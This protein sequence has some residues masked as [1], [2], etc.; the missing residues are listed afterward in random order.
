MVF[1]HV[2]AQNRHREIP[3]ALQF[4]TYVAV[5]AVPANQNDS[6]VTL[7]DPAPALRFP[8]WEPWLFRLDVVKLHRQVGLSGLGLEPFKER[9]VLGSVNDEDLSHDRVSRFNLIK[10]AYIVA[11]G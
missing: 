7:I 10:N 3:G 4:P 1:V 11:C 6:C 8:G 5:D 2:D 9:I